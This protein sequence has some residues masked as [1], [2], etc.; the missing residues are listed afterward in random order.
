M[1]QIETVSRQSR[2]VFGSTSRVNSIETFVI[3]VSSTTLNSSNAD[4]RV[5]VCCYGPMASGKI[6]IE[7]RGDGGG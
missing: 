2:T 5:G 7:G 1:S 6:D 4:L 3:M